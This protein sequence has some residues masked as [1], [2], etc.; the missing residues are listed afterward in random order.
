MYLDMFGIAPTILESFRSGNLHH[1]K[2]SD[3]IR[4]HWPLSFNI[5]Y[6]YICIDE[7]KE[8]T[9]NASW[10]SIFQALTCPSCSLLSTQPTTE[11][12]ESGSLQHLNEQFTC[13][14]SVIYDLVSNR[15]NARPASIRNNQY[16][17]HHRRRRRRRRRR[18]NGKRALHYL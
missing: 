10:R 17:H 3:G 13:T 5:I 18:W 15:V 6:F 14:K 8:K 11:W 1:K 2:W 9:S 4:F 7:R 12:N 16:H